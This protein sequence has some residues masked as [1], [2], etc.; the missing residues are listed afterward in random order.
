V[1]TTQSG[2]TTKTT[3][4]TN[5]SGGHGGGAIV[6][7]GTCHGGGTFELKAKHDDGAIEVEFEVD[8]NRAGQVWAVRLTDNGVTVFSGHATT[9]RPSGSFSLRKVIANRAGADA[10]HATATMGARTCRG[11]VT[12]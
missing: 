6:S 9:T 4:T 7:R 5:A 8:T 11:T 3:K 10:V 2:K 12:A 1:H